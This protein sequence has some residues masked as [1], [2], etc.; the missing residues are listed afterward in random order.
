MAKLIKL[1][2]SLKSWKVVSC[3]SKTN[4][5][6]VYEVNKK[7]YDGTTLS[8]KLI[9]SIKRDDEYTGENI[10][11][12]TDEADFIK[13]VSGISDS[14]NYLDVSVENTPSKEK[15]E[16]FV[17]TENLQTLADYIKSKELSE[18]QIVDFG[19]QI[20]ELLEKLESNNIYHGNLNLDN[21]Y[22]DNDGN[23][24]IGGFLEFESSNSNTY[25]TAPEIIKGENADFT[26]D[27]YSLGLIMHY[28]SNNYSL[29][30][31]S[32]TV[33]KQ[34]ATEL[35]LNGKQVT[36]PTNG[37]E[38]LKSVIVI[39]CQS[40][41]NNRWKNASNIKNA[42]TSI[43]GELKPEVPHER[44]II[45]ESTE[46]SG[47]VFE[48][49]EYEE[50]ADDVQQNEIIEET[51]I[52]EELPTETA[53]GTTEGTAQID[54]I[55]NS[56]NEDTNVDNPFSN[57]DKSS[58]EFE[59]LPDVKEATDSVESIAQ[60]EP[61]KEIITESDNNADDI[62]EEIFDNYDININS[63]SFKL[64]DNQKDYGNYFDED[65]PVKAT[66]KVEPVNNDTEKEVNIFED[67]DFT[68]QPKE[69]AKKSKKNTVVIVICIVVMLA[70]LGFIAYCI[71]GG[72][73]RNK[74][75][76]PTDPITTTA[77]ETT[78][79]PTTVAP[80]TIAPTTVAPQEINVVPVVGYGYSYGKKLLEEAG[81]TV[82]V[83]EYEYSESYPEGYIIA[84][85]P[86]GDT[87]AKNGTVVKLD[88]SLGLI[89]PTTEE[90]TTI[91]PATEAPHTNPP[92]SSST[93]DKDSTYIFSNSSTAYLSKADVAALN[94]TNLNLALNEI[95]ARRGRIF[96]DASL[97]SYFNSKTWYTP[98]YTSEE[99]AQKV[100]FN[101]YEQKNLQ[102]MIDEQKNRGYR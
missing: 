18:S 73:S 33:D 35:R 32:D 6:E 26:T 82:E 13:T 68:E 19:I 29:P 44:V 95:Y 48:E 76:K 38:K 72:L 12:M 4:E 28:L 90:P 34:A 45:P 2:D 60:V 85:T 79:P 53:E 10:D 97:A 74:S 3:L 16:L 57:E 64:K 21:I 23:Y 31:E 99:F 62:T 63:N 50:F 22:I 58:F 101:T 89:E 94:Q 1:P 40:N 42:L 84:Q 11:Y 67:D 47:N 15:V 51:Q 70:A 75:N 83:G 80:T 77:I 7:E 27:L 55:T 81:F 41:N 25:F 36:A 69:N 59:E 49:F 93:S 24:K 5:C 71:I 17:V 30:F 88:I 54:E 98:K 87:L 46:F 37:S 92:E 61:K 78:I 43:K 39:A 20:S 8:A 66:P 52:E 9:Y 65:E 14:F 86:N 96:K 91:E 56:E 102:L 100:T